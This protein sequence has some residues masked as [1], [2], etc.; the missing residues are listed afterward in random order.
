MAVSNCDELIRM[1]GYECRRLEGLIELTTPV[2]LP[3]GAPV[4]AYFSRQPS[5]LIEVDDGGELLLEAAGLGML[6][7][8]RFEHTFAHRVEAAGATFEQGR[9]VVRSPPRR[10]WEAYTA[11]L[12]AAMAVADYIN[13]RRI[14]A[15]SEDE[16]VAEIEAAV[17]TRVPDARIDRD[18]EVKG[19]SGLTHRFRLK[20]NRTLVEPLRPSGRSTGPALRRILDVVKA[21]QRA[22][23][24]MDDRSSREDADREATIVSGVT[25]VY[26]LSRLEEGA[27]VDELAA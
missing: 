27:G 17:R 23:V 8:R 4:R 14:L 18:V 1:L 12:R 22:V 20:V 25:K 15:R 9:V 10:L 26:F 3:G 11:F 16:L 24:V 6:E 13:E 21:D 2:T 5:G 7:L 19:A